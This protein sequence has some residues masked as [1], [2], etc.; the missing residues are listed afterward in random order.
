M[1][2]ASAPLPKAATAAPPS[3]EA[4][5]RAFRMALA[6]AEEFAGA[7]APNPPVGCAVLDQA[8]AVIACEAHRMAG[9]AHAEA[10][11]ID[12]CRRAGEEARIHTL[13]VT[14]EP[15]NHTGRTPPCVEAVLSTP[16]RAVW[17]GAP[18]PNPKVAG[19]GAARLAAAGLEVR[20]LDDLPHPEA[21]ELARAARRL[22]APFAVWSRTGRP[23]VT[24]K[25]A[26]DAE[27]GMIPPP[28][29]T[30]FTSEESLTLAH[31]LRR[32]CD[33]IVTGSGCVLADDPAFTVRRVPDHPGKRRKLAILDRRG[34]TPASYVEAA[35]ARGFEV[36][37]RP[38]L[39]RLLAE[40]GEAGVLEALVEAGPT[41]LDAILER[42]LWDEHV[43]I[44]QSATSGRPDAVERR[45]RRP[46]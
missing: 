20:R 12:A 11:A 4:V 2:L 25:Q 23:W 22:I 16:A 24:V 38:D 14:L 31:Q 33:A 40:L 41:L 27:G 6:R 45:T 29:R 44:R 35:Q 5:A 17:I 26:L 39:D 15:C 37:V 30:T 9:Q 21:A 19:G 28:G 13:V 36:W 18:D 43:V 7:T 32:R 1:T 34:R 42:G 3:P 8:G 10:A 46:I